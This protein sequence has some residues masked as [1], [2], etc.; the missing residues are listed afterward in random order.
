MRIRSLCT[1]MHAMGVRFPCQHLGFILRTCALPASLT[2][3]PNNY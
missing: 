1:D 3:L 2:W